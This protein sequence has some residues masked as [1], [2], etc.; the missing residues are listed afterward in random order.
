MSLFHE[1]SQERLSK[2]DAI[3]EGGEQLEILTLCQICLEAVK[4][5]VQTPC[6]HVFCAEDL[7][8]W[9]RNSNTR[10]TCRTPCTYEAV[11][12]RSPTI[13]SR[14]GFE[15]PP[16]LQHLHENM[17][18]LH[19]DM[20]TM[21]GDMRDLSSMLTEMRASLRELR[22]RCETR[23]AWLAERRAMLDAGH[24]DGAGADERLTGHD[25]EINSVLAALTDQEAAIEALAG[26][27]AAELAY[28]GTRHA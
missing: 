23:R 5:A 10:P 24:R 11:F 19:E 14:S 21:R 13:E 28:R 2:T 22:A 7:T 25:A 27:R 15:Q 8:T 26:Y 9:L 4:E 16:T 1:R 17:Q 20:I 3:T 18:R 6:A 12:K